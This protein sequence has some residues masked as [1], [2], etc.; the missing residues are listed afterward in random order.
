MTAVYFGNSFRPEIWDRPPVEVSATKTLTKDCFGRTHIVL[1]PTNYVL[2][3]PVSSFKMAGRS[4]LFTH[5]S[6]SGTVT[7][8]A[9][10]GNTIS[11]NG[12]T[13]PSIQMT[14]G[15]AL[16]LM[17]SGRNGFILVAKGGD[18]SLYPEIDYSGF[19]PI[20]S[21]KFTG[22]PQAPYPPLLDS[23]KTMAV[24]K[25]ILDSIKRAGFLLSSG[26]YQIT[27][28][29][30]PGVSGSFITNKASN[31]PTGVGTDGF[32]ISRMYGENGFQF[33]APFNGTEVYWRRLY[34]GVWYDWIALSKLDSPSLTGTPTTPYLPNRDQPL[35]A[36][37]VGDVGTLIEEKLPRIVTKRL[38]FFSNG[39]WIAPFTGTLWVSGRGGGGGGGSVFYIRYTGGPLTAGKQGGSVGSGGGGAGA[40]A[41]KIP[42]DVVEGTSYSIL[43]G[44][45]GASRPSWQWVGKGGTTS[46]GDILVLEGGDPGGGYPDNST[47]SAGRFLTNIIGG[48]GGNGYLNGVLDP[49][50]KGQAGTYSKFFNQAQYSFAS[51]GGTGGGPSGGSGACQGAASPGNFEN[52]ISNLAQPGG[53]GCGGGGGGVEYE[54]VISGSA[55][56]GSTN[57]MIGAPGGQGYLI[58]EWLE[59]TT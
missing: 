46:F 54:T 23:S 21:A 47:T 55:T 42:V 8:Q 59:Q 51:S 53:L 29:N 30:N 25:W 4:I 12:S 19:A 58:L 52:K 33:Y 7:I 3:L 38:R 50:F 27:D 39:E 48:A 57:A 16:C 14:V 20:D 32:L 41:D 43:I 28:A 31:L 49:R 44:E 10:G 11:Y 2:T 37:N 45:G 35:Q 6:L 18:P 26:S 40:V 22:D 17:D 9:Q 24:T 15:E 56:N 34:N 13:H 5:G 36:I 1:T